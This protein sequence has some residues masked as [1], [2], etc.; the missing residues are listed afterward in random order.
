MAEARPVT[1]M[2]VDGQRRLILGARQRLLALWIAEH[3]EIVNSAGLEVLEFVC[4]PSRGMAVDPRWRMQ[5]G[6]LREESD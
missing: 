1:V 5:G 6:R 4:S 2:L 3:P